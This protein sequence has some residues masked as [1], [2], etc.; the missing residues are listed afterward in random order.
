MM[1][2]NIQPLVR[3][4][5]PRK[6]IGTSLMCSVTVALSKD[7]NAILQAQQTTA[8]EFYNR[9]LYLLRNNYFYHEHQAGKAEQRFDVDSPKFEHKYP[10]FE[11]IYSVIKTYEQYA[12]LPASVA[13]EI[14]KLVVKNMIGFKGLVAGKFKGSLD[15]GLKINLP[16]YKKV[17]NEETDYA[18]KRK[19]RTLVMTYSGG[20]IS[21]Q[22]NLITLSAFK[23]LELKTKIQ[24]KL[25]GYLENRDIRTVSLLEQGSG[26]IA[27]VT[28]LQEPLKAVNE[29]PTRFLGM[30]LNINTIATINNVNGEALLI[31]LKQLKSINRY[32]NKLKAKYQSLMAIAKNDDQRQM[33]FAKL[34]L[35]SKK[36]NNQIRDFTFKLANQLSVY[37]ER[38]QIDQVIIGYNPNWK[39]SVNLGKRTNQTFTSIPFKMMIDRISHHLLK[40]GIGCKTQEESY[41]SKCDHLASEPMCKQDSYL[42]H[43]K[44]RGLFKSSIKT[45][46]G[47]NIVCQADV[48]GAMGI[49]RKSI[50]ES[51]VKQIAVMGVFFRPKMVFVLK[52]QAR[53]LV[54][55]LTG[56][57]VRNIMPF[58]TVAHIT[59]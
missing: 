40:K 14:A 38:N 33:L 31:S 46:T 55:S 51:V 36:R 19:I 1:E 50:G 44:H 26:F 43:R 9:V 30:D 5:H 47:K 6:D 37:C 32:F 18:L 41:T 15:K 25:P 35:L 28:Y 58:K 8:I 27:K 24:F 52:H 10:T 16:R 29:N 13:Q 57:F 20:N 11:S 4:K 23:G 7:Y 17:Y 42:G 56:F 22:G 54:K 2:N 49:L 39:Q 12:L 34:R 53:N 21:K 3:K 59:A 48:W 45:Q